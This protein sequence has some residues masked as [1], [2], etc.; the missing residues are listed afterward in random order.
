MRSLGA[1]HRKSGRAEPLV[2]AAL[3]ALFFAL[4]LNLSGVFEISFGAVDGNERTGLIGAAL[5]GVLA[6]VAASPCTAPFMG[7]ALGYALTQSAVEALAV[8]LMRF[9]ASNTPISTPNQTAPR[10]RPSSR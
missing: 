7:A 6:V 8:F 3:A 9:T 4:A 1:F 10:S 5:N 2:I